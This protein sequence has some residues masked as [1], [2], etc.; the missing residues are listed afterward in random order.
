VIFF[1]AVGGFFLWC[2]VCLGVGVWLVFVF[3][4]GVGVGL[5]GVL[6]AGGAL[7]GVGGGGGGKH[8]KPPGGC[9]FGFFGCFVVFGGVGVF[10][11]LGVWG[12][13][14]LPKIV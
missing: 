4:G 9:F 5:G 6:L 3:L 7:G 10:F 13:I 2:G 11:V 12:D 8:K 1:V 14:P